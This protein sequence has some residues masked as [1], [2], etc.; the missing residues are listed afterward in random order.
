MYPLNLFVKLSFLNAAMNRL[1]HGPLLSRADF[2]TWK[3]HVS[4]DSIFVAIKADGPRLNL[5]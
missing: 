2:D 4:I 3:T 1:Q 5:C